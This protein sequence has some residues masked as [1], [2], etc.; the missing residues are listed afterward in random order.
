MRRYG[1]ARISSQGQDVDVQR[2]K[3]YKA[4]CDAIASEE[5]S[6]KL[7]ELIGMMHND[8]TLVV[9]RLDRLGSSTEEIRALLATLVKRDIRLR[10]IDQHID[11]G[12]G[13][14]DE[15][16][17][18]NIF[19]GLADMDQLAIAEGARPERATPGRK[20]N[21][22]RD[23]ILRDLEAMTA[24]AVAK[25]HGI[26]PR[27]V[28]RIKRAAAPTLEQP[29]PR[30]KP[31]PKTAPAKKRKTKPAPPPV[32]HDAIGFTRPKGFKDFDRAVAVL[33]SVKDMPRIDRHEWRDVGS[34]QFMTVRDAQKRIGKFRQAHHDAEITERF[35]GTDQTSIELLATYPDQPDHKLV[36]HARSR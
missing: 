2:D 30:S 33:E 4:G 24:A 10:V 35:M 9:T 23:A 18:L 13:K 19:S 32:N 22:N 36:C 28:Y 31:K 1:Y 29:Q 25:K 17:L 14:P 16:T 8:D 15:K 11:T 6:D 34:R 20:P 21:P 27:T 5:G 3:L 26:S 12:A 7:A